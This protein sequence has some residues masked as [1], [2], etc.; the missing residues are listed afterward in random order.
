[1]DGQGVGVWVL[2][3]DFSSLHV[4]H[5]SLCRWAEAYTSFLFLQAS[6]NSPAVQLRLSEER[7][8]SK[9]LATQVLLRIRETETLLGF[10]WGSPTRKVLTL[11]CERGFKEWGR[12]LATASA[13]VGAVRFLMRLLSRDCRVNAGNLIFASLRLHCTR[14]LIL[15]RVEA[16]SSNVWPWLGLRSSQPEA[17]QTTL[18]ET[19]EVQVTLWSTVSW[20][21]CLNVE[22]PI[23]FPPYLW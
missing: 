3:Y 18:D 16:R 17:S 2:V 23:L 15:N 12:S 13:Y 11:K 22:H 4:V 6:D 19:A 1:M 8:I 5:T 20:T 7:E 9:S 21:V 14:L 10:N